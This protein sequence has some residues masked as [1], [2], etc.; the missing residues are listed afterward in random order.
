MLGVD[1][2]AITLFNVRISLAKSLQHIT[3]DEGPTLI[4]PNSELIIKG[5]KE[6][7]I[8]KVF[9]TEIHKVIRIS[10]L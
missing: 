1:Y 3:F 4:V 5:I 7:A 8:I 10:P 6:E 2:L 9:S